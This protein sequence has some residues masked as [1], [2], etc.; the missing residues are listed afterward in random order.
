MIQG[1]YIPRSNICIK[2]HLL[3]FLFSLAVSVFYHVHLHL[4]VCFFTL[5]FHS[6]LLFFKWVPTPNLED[7]GFVIWLPLTPLWG[8]YHSYK[9]SLPIW[10]NRKVQSGQIGQCRTHLSDPS[11][12]ACSTLP[13]AMLAQPSVS[14]EYTNLST[15]T[16]SASL[17]QLLK[18][19]T[20]TEDSASLDHSYLILMYMCY[21]LWQKILNMK[22]LFLLL[23]FY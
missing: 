15:Q 4:T 17:R 1:L 22:E 14:L 2:F 10:Q 16:D 18:T 5:K 3:L 6:N 11:V 21:P 8:L 7:Q 13:V 19:V 20:V 9:A 23:E 12:E